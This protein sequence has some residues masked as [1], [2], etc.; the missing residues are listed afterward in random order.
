MALM[1]IMV[2]HAV[3]LAG[4]KRVEVKADDSWTETKLPERWYEPDGFA[5]DVPAGLV[6]TLT[7]AV[8]D[9]GNPPRLFAFLPAG[10]E[11]KNVLRLTVKPSET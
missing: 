3:I 6:D 11:E 4:L 1:S 9:A 10:D 2:S 7:Q 8:I 5:Y